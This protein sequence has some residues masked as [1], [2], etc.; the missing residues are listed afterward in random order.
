MRLTVTTTQGANLEAAATFFPGD[1]LTSSGCRRKGKWALCSEVLRHLVGLPPASPCLTFNDL[2]FLLP[3]FSISRCYFL[4]LDHTGFV[5]VL[6]TG[7]NFISPGVPLFIF[8]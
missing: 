7:F 2:R 3:L 1:Q 5:V 4:H 8:F 6:N